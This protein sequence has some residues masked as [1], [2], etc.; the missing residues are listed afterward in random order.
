M[1]RADAPA[2]TRDRASQAACATRMRPGVWV[3]VPPMDSGLSWGARA[4]VI[5]PRG[6]PARDSSGVL[7][8][9][10][11]GN[12]RGGISGP[13]QLRAWSWGRRPGAGRRPRW[14]EA[15]NLADTRQLRPAAF[16][17]ASRPAATRR[18]RPLRPGRERASPR[19]V[20]TCSRFELAATTSPPNSGAEPPA[21]STRASTRRTAASS[22]SRRCKRNGAE[23]DGGRR[24]D[25]GCASATRRAPSAA[26]A[27]R[28]SSPSTS[29]ARTACTAG[30]RWSTSRAA[31]STTCCCATPCRA[32]NARWPS[33]T[34]CWTRSAAC[35]A[36]ASATAT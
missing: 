25:P 15:P 12:T 23:G 18:A 9:A 14:P 35:I 20:P 31:T 24:R 11:Q 21:S 22:R 34:N 36:K 13:V 16:G 33:W 28:A 4:D 10:A 17:P 5:P 30:S 1:V 7:D 19:I 32:R 3:K 26:C 2:A 6:R 29:S 27:I 8:S